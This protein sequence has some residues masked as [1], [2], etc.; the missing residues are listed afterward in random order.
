MYG[1]FDVWFFWVGFIGFNERCVNSI[2]KCGLWIVVIMEEV[3]IF[4]D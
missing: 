2:D 3:L 1:V 4:V